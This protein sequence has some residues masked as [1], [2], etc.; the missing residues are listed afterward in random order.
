MKKCQPIELIRVLSKLAARKGRSILKTAWSYLVPLTDKAYQA[1][2]RVAR[3]FA[4]LATKQLRRAAKAAKQAFLG[5]FQF[6]WVNG[7]LGIWAAAALVLICGMIYTGNHFT[8]GVRVYLGEEHIATMSSQD[9]F[10]Q[11]LTTAEQDISDAIGDSFTT[12]EVFSYDTRVVKKN[13]VGYC[14]SM[15]SLLLRDGCGIVE[16]TTLTVDDE[17]IGAYEDRDALEQMLDEIKQ[18]HALGVEGEELSFADN[19]V[20]QTKLGKTSLL[21][22]LDAMREYLTEPVTEAGCYTIQSGDTF[23]AIAPRYGMSAEELMDLNNGEDPGTL[24]I[25]DEIVVSAEVPRLTVK[26][27]YV[28]EYDEAIPYE[29][30]WVADSD[31]YKNRTRT[32]VEGQDGSQQVTAEITV[33]NGN[34]IGREILETTVLEE[35][36][37]AQKAYGTKEL[38]P[39]VATGTFRKPASGIITLR[40]GARDGLHSSYHTG[41]DIANSRGTAIYSADAGKVTFAG[42]KGSYGYLIIIDHENG[43]QT[44]YAHCSKLYVSRGDRVYKGQNIAAMGSTGNSTGTHLHFEIRV[45]GNPV[46]PAKYVSF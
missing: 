38:P 2:C 45:N 27:T 13:E 26:S 32:I 29:T 40:F 39:T 36:V 6:S 5:L 31:L 19:V 8:V 10:L 35:P 12:S 46:N 22:N 15:A 30:E 4:P 21:K 37:T 43:Y 18:E 44:Y 24:Q 16:L 28:E 17:L 11:R 23:S 42:W 34:E 41:I 33:E 9:E 25:G 3:K 14:E 1:V 7:H 20:L